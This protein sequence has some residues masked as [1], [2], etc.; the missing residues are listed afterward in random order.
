M[1][2]LSEQLEKIAQENLTTRGNRRFAHSYI[3]RHLHE[4]FRWYQSQGMPMGDFVADVR[5]WLQDNRQHI[6]S[7]LEG[8]QGTELGKRQPG[9]SESIDETL[10]RYEI[11]GKLVEAFREKSNG[12]IIGGSLSYGPFFNVRGNHDETGASDIDGIVVLNDFEKH[13][14]ERPFVAPELFD[15]GDVGQLDERLREFQALYSA[16]QADIFTQ[17][18]TARGRDFD[19]SL[20]FMLQHEFDKLVGSGFA[21]AL[22]DGHDQNYVMKDFRSKPFV[23]PTVPLHGFDKDDVFSV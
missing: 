4:A 11:A 16:G 21:N 2:V 5:L 10:L 23:H 15:D 13:D 3:A 17:K 8:E 1:D 14:G 18:S 12:I 7:E 9:L 19:V 6:P 20:H 22:Q